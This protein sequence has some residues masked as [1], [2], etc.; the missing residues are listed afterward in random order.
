MHLNTP[1]AVHSKNFLTTAS[2]C[3]CQDLWHPSKIQSSST[4]K[5][6]FEWSLKNAVFSNTNTPVL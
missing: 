1:I 3:C 5:I 4:D 6:H 2:K